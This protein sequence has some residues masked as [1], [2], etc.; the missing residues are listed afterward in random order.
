VVQVFLH[1]DTQYL[2]PYFFGLYQIRYFMLLALVVSLFDIKNDFK[3]L[4]WGVCLASVL[5]IFESFATTYIRGGVGQRLGS[6]NFAVNVFGN[7]L[8]ALALFLYFG[9]RYVPVRNGAKLFL[10]ICMLSLVAAMLLTGTKGSLFSLLVSFVLLW[11]Y[12]GFKSKSSYLLFYGPVL[13]F[14]SAAVYFFYVYVGHLVS[15]HLFDDGYVYDSGT[16][17]LRT[18]VV[19][20]GITL[21]MIKD[22]YIFGIGN[23][24]WNYLKYDYGS[25]FDVLLDPHNDY[26]NFVVN[27]GVVGVGA[28][29]LCYLY[30]LYNVL[31]LKMRST[32]HNFANSDYVVFASFIIPLAISSFTNANT[33]KHQVF[34]LFILF[35]LF[36]Y[37]FYHVPE[38]KIKMI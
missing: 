9:R 21:D 30:P 18:R 6:G 27:Y 29:F 20:W 14:V 17:S 15:L 34:A 1:F 4:F 11:R 2:G 23:G 12:A 3:Y 35:L 31:F 19:L 7:L 8:A 36:S 38:Y 16:S 24:L 26:L 33:A 25:P 10:F 22:H 28:V 5:L 32:S 13:L 37:K